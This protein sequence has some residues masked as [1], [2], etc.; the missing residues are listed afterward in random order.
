[1]GNNQNDA[2]IGGCLYLNLRISS[3]LLKIFATAYPW[4]LKKKVR[5]ICHGKPVK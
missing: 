2:G 3:D 5:N 1:M 4:V